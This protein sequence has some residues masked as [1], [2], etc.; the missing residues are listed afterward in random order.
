MILLGLFG[1]IFK[2]VAGSIDVITMAA[3]GSINMPNQI[4]KN[5]FKL[6]HKNKKKEIHDY[7][8]GSF[9]IIGK[10]LLN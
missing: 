2:P 8:Y 3:R 1:V 7:D 10:Y 9:E 6:V 5:I 4:Y